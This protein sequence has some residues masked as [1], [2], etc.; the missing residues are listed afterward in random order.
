MLD[1]YNVAYGKD[2]DMLGLYKKTAQAL[3][4][5]RE[6]SPIVPRAAR[7][8]NVSFRTSLQRYSR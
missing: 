8:L 6:A 7:R 1:D 2:D 4:I 5:N 3:K